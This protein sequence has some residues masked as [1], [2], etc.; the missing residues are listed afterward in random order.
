[1]KLTHYEA[2]EVLGLEVW[3]G[4]PAVQAALHMII[5]Y[6][7]IREWAISCNFSPRCCI[8]VTPDVDYSWLHAFRDCWACRGL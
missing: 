4:F 8:N 3:R 2:L 5:L 7:I 1:M 6:N